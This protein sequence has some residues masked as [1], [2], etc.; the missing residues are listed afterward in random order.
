MKAVQLYLY[1]NK[2]KEIIKIEEKNGKKFVN[3][4]ELHQFL[5]VG[6]DFSNWIK[7]RIEKYEFIEGQDFISFA[8][9]GER[10]IGA[11]VRK[12]Y[13]ISIS[14]AKELC[15]IEN[16]ERGKKARKYFI[17]CEQK[18]RGIYSS[19]QMPSTFAEALQLAADQQKQIEKQ[20]KLLEA[21]ATEILALNDKVTE[22]QPKA[23]YYDQILSSQNTILTTQIAK[24]YGYSAQK[25]NKILESLH[26][27]Y[28]LRGQW[29][30]YAE[31]AGNGYTKSVSMPFEYNDGTSGTRIQTE[32]TQK[33]RLFL[34]EKLKANDILPI[35][36][37]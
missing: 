24:D 9:I 32:W 23:K 20:Q 33:G 4:R 27:Q 15:M 37:K 19:F 29:L 2:M 14:M 36:E 25:F 6:R 31:H 7:H 28:R 34:Y 35:I 1:H 26:I 10:A 13:A 16:N 18:L 11:V 12:E 3:A 22:M 17:A 5:N 30:L 21:N 8:K